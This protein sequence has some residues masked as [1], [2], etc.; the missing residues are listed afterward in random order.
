M[1]DITDLQ[2]DPENTEGLKRA[3]ISIVSDYVIDIKASLIK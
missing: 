2:T 3:Y 1:G